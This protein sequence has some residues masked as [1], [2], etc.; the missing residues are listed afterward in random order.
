MRRLVLVCALSLPVAAH[1]D[2]VSP[3][4]DQPAVRHKLELREGR[5]EIAPTFEGSIS[6]DFKYTLSGGLKVEYHVNDWLSVGGLAFFGGAINSDLF[7]KVVGTLPE[8]GE[9]TYPTPSKTTAE[10]HVNTMPLHG[11]VGLTLTPWSGKLSLFGKIFAHYDIYFSGGFGFAQTKNDFKTKN[12]LPGDDKDTACDKNCDDPDPTKRIFDDPRNDGP[13]NAGFNAGVQFGG[14]FH[15][16]FSQ[17]AALD[18]YIRDYM[19]A[20][21]PAGLDFNGDFKVDSDDRRFLSHLFVGIG[22]AIYLP[23]RADISK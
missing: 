17:F 4:A 16:F 21:N 13:H 6:A 9:D 14:G 2:R 5:I 11:G 10:Q 15:F 7:D 1:A 18:I 3:L 23:A 12:G 8:T 20:D 22:I 19:F